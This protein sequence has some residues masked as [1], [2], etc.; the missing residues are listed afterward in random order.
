M[1][2]MRHEAQYFLVLTSP[3]PTHRRSRVDAR[4]THRWWQAIGYALCCLDAGALRIAGQSHSRSAGRDVAAL[5][6]RVCIPHAPARPSGEKQPLEASTCG[7]SRHAPELAH[8]S[9]AA[10]AMAAVCL[11]PRVVEFGTLESGQP[12]RGSPSGRHWGCLQSLRRAGHRGIKGPGTPGG[13]VKLGVRSAGSEGIR[14][15]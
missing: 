3:L 1:A 13:G 5:A 8:G 7:M 4:G 12:A 10:A 6:W 9:P 14:G 15:I 11:G 2:S